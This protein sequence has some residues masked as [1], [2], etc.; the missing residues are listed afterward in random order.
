MPLKIILHKS[1]IS[2]ITHCMHG[3][4][5]SSESGGRIRGCGISGGVYGIEG[6]GCEWVENER[7]T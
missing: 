7:C 1:M 2:Y 3:L 4:G 5:E 6:G